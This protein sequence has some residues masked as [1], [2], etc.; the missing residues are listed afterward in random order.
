MKIEIDGKLL[1][2]GFG[3][4]PLIYDAADRA[5]VSVERFIVN[6][7]ESIADEEHTEQG[8]PERIASDII[9]NRP[10]WLKLLPHNHPD[11][12]TAFEYRESE[13]KRGE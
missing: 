10:S 6:T 9:D 1:E 13:L 12:L 11:Y 2:M 3:V 5:G 4:V 7:L 8:R